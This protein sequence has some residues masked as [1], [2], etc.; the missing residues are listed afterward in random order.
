MMY[1]LC[2]KAFRCVMR[3]ESSSLSLFSLYCC[4][5]P[6]APYMGKEL[7]ARTRA[8]TLRGDSWVN[9]ATYRKKKKKHT[10]LQTAHSYGDIQDQITA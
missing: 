10:L 7:V 4:P 9:S 8:E 3:K 2:C 6:L 5:L 1:Y